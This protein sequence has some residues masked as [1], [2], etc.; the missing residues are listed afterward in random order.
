MAYRQ[1]PKTPSET[2]PPSPSNEI[3]IE[4]RL[5]SLEQEDLDRWLDQ[6]EDEFQVGRPANQPAPAQREAANLSHINIEE[7][8]RELD[9][10]GVTP[11]PLEYYRSPEFENQNN[12]V[13]EGLRENLA[14]SP[15]TR[16]PAGRV[17][18]VSVRPSLLGI[19]LPPATSD[20]PAP[21]NSN[22]HIVIIEDD[23]EGYEG[24]GSAAEARADSPSAPIPPIRSTTTSDE[25]SE[26][27]V[28]R[29]KKRNRRRRKRKHTAT[30]EEH[31]SPHV[32]ISDWEE[33]PG[34]P[35]DM[36]R[37]FPLFIDNPDV[38]F[39]EEVL[40]FWVVVD[41]LTHVCLFCCATDHVT[42]RCPGRPKHLSEQ[43]TAI[44]SLM[45]NTQINLRD[46][47]VKIIQYA[48][49]E[50][51]MKPQQ[52]QT[53]FLGF[54]LLQTLERVLPG[55]YDKEKLH[56]HRTELMEATLVNWPE[57]HTSFEARSGQQAC[58]QEALETT[59]TRATASAVYQ[60]RSLSTLPQ[61]SAAAGRAPSSEDE[62]PVSA[63]RYCLINLID[64]RHLAGLQSPWPVLAAAFCHP[65]EVELVGARLRL[66][67]I[68]SLLTLNWE[69]IE[70]KHTEILN[71]A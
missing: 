24:E 34:Q 26:P 2:P 11:R 45:L 7:L 42:S 5:H 54:G 67:L 12:Q 17:P 19:S 31:T 71:G 41:A 36:N 4:M 25:P 37:G 56:M 62:A 22:D 55:K 14:Q 47:R 27:V 13:M 30:P 59:P 3:E 57:V 53:K 32:S 18:A 52:I 65:E 16:G 44:K 33:E 58:G 48:S 29:T 6:V 38:C 23:E 35:E 8:R 15:F 21:A 51:K 10:L 66:I 39:P 60:S 1:G 70:E 64:V 9:Q 50:L 46:L 63:K 61:P 40:R 20:T 43:A 69:E 49:K 28:K 68:M